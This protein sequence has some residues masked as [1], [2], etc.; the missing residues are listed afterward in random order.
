MLPVMRPGDLPGHIIIP[1]INYDDY[2]DKRFKQRIRLAGE[3]LVR[4]GLKNIVF[5]A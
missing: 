3:S 5:G 4:L 2:N 1:E